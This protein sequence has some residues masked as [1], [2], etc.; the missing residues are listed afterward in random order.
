MEACCALTKLLLKCKELLCQQNNVCFFFFLGVLWVTERKGATWLVHCLLNYKGS[1][2]QRL[3]FLF[4]QF[5][6]SAW[7]EDIVWFE[8][9]NS[10][11]SLPP[12]KKCRGT[13]GV[14]LITFWDD[15]TFASLCLFVSGRSWREGQ[16]ARDLKISTS[17]V[18]RALVWQRMN[19]TLW[20]EEEEEP[21][22]V[23]C[24]LFK[25]KRHFEKR[26]LRGQKT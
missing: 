5:F 3:I 26:Y 25:D 22:T 17:A 24:L 10:T 14:S 9:I 21:W 7:K 16:M 12:P 19:I 20:E 23:D 13:N 4:F 11:I 18:T 6:Y 8:S 1:N 15:A 2:I